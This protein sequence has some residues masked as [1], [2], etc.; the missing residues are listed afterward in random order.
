MRMVRDADT[1]RIYCE[2]LVC[3]KGIFKG[4]VCDMAV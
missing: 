3:A 1:A 2:T 4:S